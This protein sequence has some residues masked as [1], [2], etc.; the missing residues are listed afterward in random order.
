MGTLLNNFREKQHKSWINELQQDASRLRDYS[1]L[2]PDVGGESYWY[3]VLDSFELNEVYE[4]F[5]KTDADEAAGIRRQMVPRYFDRSKWWDRWDE[6]RLAELDLPVAQTRENMRKAA[7]RKMDDVLVDGMFASVME[8]KAGVIT[9]MGVLAENL[10]GKDYV[11]SGTAAEAN[12]TIDKL[13]RA[14]EILEENDS[15][16]ERNTGG[17]R[18]IFVGSTRQKS[19]LL[20]SVE[21]KSADYNDVK[22]LVNGKVDE[23]LGIRF[24]WTNRLPKGED[25][26]RKC[27]LYVRSA[28]SFGLW[29]D[30]SIE[31]GKDMSHKG[32]LVM[33]GKMA[34]GAARRFDKAFVQVDCKE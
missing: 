33:I 22:A 10:V 8:K 13:I 9:P 4:R 6:K 2:V 20:R 32:A 3:D 26:V 21:V 18:L 16:D 19:A 23:F 27:M 29:D 25:G 5:G 24:V 12:L 1:T 30:M 7:N 15:W 31:M 34:C 28:M 11:S 17:D 14:R